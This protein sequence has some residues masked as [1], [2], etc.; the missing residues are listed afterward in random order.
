MKE[1]YRKIAM[2]AAVL[3]GLAA[4]LYLGGV[5]G[6]ILT[7]YSLWMK[8]G[9][10]GGQ[11][12][13]QPVNFQ[14]GYCFQQ[15]FSSNGI[16]GT[17]FLLAAGI[18]VF[19]YIRLHNKLEN[20][21]YDERGF[22]VVKNGTYGTASWMNEKEMQKVLEISPIEKAEG[23]ILGEYQGKAVCMPKDTR[24]NRHIAVFGASGTMKSRAVI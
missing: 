6:Q 23:T 16:K 7:N 10:M 22:K 8:Q 18:G 17:L 14:P 1:S 3:L 21:D 20:N 11:V 2:I 13:M 5:I 19:A 12:T 24:L 9:G 15:A 4:L